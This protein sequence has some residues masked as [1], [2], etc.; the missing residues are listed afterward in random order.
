[1]TAEIAIINKIAVALAADSAVTI[2]ERDSQHKKIY[3]SEEKLFELSYTDPVGIMINN[4]MNFCET[5]IQILIDRYR[6]MDR[7]FGKIEEYAK[8]FREFLLDFSKHTDNEI[9]LRHVRAH[10]EPIIIDIKIRCENKFWELAGKNFENNEESL[11]SSETIKNMF[12]EEIYEMSNSLS[13]INTVT[14]LVGGEKISLSSKERD[15]IKS[16]IK[17]HL[18]MFSDL[19]RD[20]VFNYIKKFIRNAFWSSATTGIVIAGFGEAELFPSL[21]SFDLHGVIGGVLRYREHKTIDVDRNGT[22]AAVLPFAQQGMVERFLHG[23][24]AD[25]QKR[26]GRIYDELLEEYSAGLIDMIRPSKT[27]RD[28]A[29]RLAAAARKVLLDKAAVGIREIRNASR[30]EIE[31]MVE[32]MPKSEIAQMAQALVNLTSIKH[33]VSRGMATV[34]GPIDV[35]VIS[36]SEGFVWIE[37]KHYFPGRLNPGYFKRI[38]IDSFQDMD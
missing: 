21:V 6:K 2:S 25:T 16:T 33:R 17:K 12:D 13:D 36:R 29:N 28:K 23:L 27:A 1:V 38:G 11:P 10:V 31:D 3:N 24:D 26:I 19:Q 37:Q 7:K 30:S 4:D 15:V 32:F 14:E 22:K 34:G 18:T 35:A 5:P 9:K 20:K 8:N